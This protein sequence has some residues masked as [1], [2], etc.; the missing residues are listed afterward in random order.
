MSSPLDA[1][2]KGSTANSYLTVL[3]ADAVARRMP[4]VS[5]WSALASTPDANGWTVTSGASTGA[6]AV[7]VTVG[8]GGLLAG[9][10]VS[11]GSDITVYTVVSDIS[12]TGDLEITPT[13]QSDVEGGV[14]VNRL[15]F[16]AKEKMLAWG[17]MLFD[18]FLEYE[19][20][21]RTTTQALRV[22][23]SGMLDLDGQFYNYDTI[24]L[25]LEEA[26]VLF[27]DEQAGTNS[28]AANQSA[29]QGFNKIKMGP[30]ELEVDETDQ[31]ALISD[32][33]LTLLQPIAQMKQSAGGGSKIHYLERY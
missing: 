17:T 13:L 31:R 2:V 14:T 9:N 3:R 21:I 19:G 6:T 16:N 28:F 22:P 20:T 33:V 15:T 25:P 30:M 1:T 4:F 10:E 26:L 32:N 27:C 8:T 23:R 18:R 29:G 11:F 7:N 24:P 12:S 5:N